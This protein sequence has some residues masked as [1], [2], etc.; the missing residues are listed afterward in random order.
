MAGWLID[1]PDRGLDKSHTQ[2]CFKPLLQDNGFGYARQLRS[3]PRV[4]AGCPHDLLARGLQLA[5]SPVKATE[6]D[7]SP[8]RALGHITSRMR[9]VMWRNNLGLCWGV[10]QPSSHPAPDV[11]LLVDLDS[12]D[13]GVHSDGVHAWHECSMPE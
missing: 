3:V 12:R 6:Y 4:R 2:C 1:E 9:Y 5:R 7:P 8:E 13:W 10:S 11:L